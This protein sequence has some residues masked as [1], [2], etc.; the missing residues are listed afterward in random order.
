MRRHFLL[1]L[2]LCML[3]PVASGQEFQFNADSAVLSRDMPVLAQEVLGA[4]KNEDRK[5]Y[6]GNAILLEIAAGQYARAIQTIH[7]LR[8]LPGSF[9]WSNAQYEAYARAKSLEAANETPLDDAYQ[10]AFR[11]VFAS[12]TDA[13]SARAMP[14]FNVV[15]ESWWK[16][17]FEAEL[18]AQKGKHTIALADAI[19]L[20]RDYQATEIYHAAARLVPALVEEDDKH[21]YINERDLKVKTPDGATVCALIMRRQKSPAQLPTLLLFTI[22]A[23][24][25]DNLNDARITAAH[26]YAGVVGFTRG[27]ACSPDTP[28]PY[29][30]DGADAATLI[31][32]IAAQPWSD[33]RVG[34]YEGSYNGFTQ[35][36]AAKHMPKA[37]KALMTGAPAAPGID[38]PMEGNVFWNFVY[39]WTFYTTDAKYND[40]ATYNDRKR[41]EKLDHDWYASGRA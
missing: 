22:Y 7:A 30:H 40:D 28:I 3:G 25:T 38:V 20:V 11:E 5:K 14:L 1:L 26:N 10:Q 23:D 27:K 24:I 16:P 32:W 2:G 35:F 9:M 13:D 29:E 21:R 18:A 4:Y 8:D 41:W 19:A 17:S 33:G 6:L 34:M 15:D 36:A 31:D 37:L 39:P 12:L